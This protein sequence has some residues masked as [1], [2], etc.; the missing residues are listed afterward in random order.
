MARAARFAPGEGD[1]GGG[2]VRTPQELALGWRDTLVA[3]D[4]R[5][6]GEL[7]ADDALFVDVEHRTPDLLEA[8]QIRGRAEIE[9]LTVGWFES[10]P[11]FSFEVV[12]VL[13]DRDSG[14]FLWTYEVPADRGPVAVDGVT[15][16]SCSNGLVNEARVYFDSYKLLTRLGLDGADRPEDG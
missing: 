4:A 16:L 1:R 15:W 14:A 8:R 7:F 3:R 6:F 13:A 9:A 10:T 11:A 2:H 12:R 5:A